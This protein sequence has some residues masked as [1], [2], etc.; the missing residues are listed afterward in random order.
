MEQRGGRLRIDSQYFTSK[1]TFFRTGEEAIC[2][3]RW[4]TSISTR[5]VQQLSEE[6]YLAQMKNLL[7]HGVDNP[8]TFQAVSYEPKAAK[9]TTPAW[10]PELRSV[11]APH[12]F[13][14]FV[15]VTARKA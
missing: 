5:K 2:G 14:T 4:R 12:I 15:I 6:Q 13:A 10:R 8:S 7:D 9:K 11:I 1:S 3:L